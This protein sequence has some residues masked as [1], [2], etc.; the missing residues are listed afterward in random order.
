MIQ[1]DYTGVKVNC[2]SVHNGARVSRP[3]IVGFLDTGEPAL[4]SLCVWN[5]IFDD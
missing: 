1:Q 3:N 2:S 4:T 5:I